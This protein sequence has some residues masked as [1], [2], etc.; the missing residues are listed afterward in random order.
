VQTFRFTIAS[1]SVAVAVVA[2]DAAWVKYVMTGRSVFGFAAAGA[3]CGL[4]LT[5][6]VLPFAL[7]AALTRRGEQRQYYAGFV[8]GGFAAALAFTC[9]TR[10]APE[11]VWGV[12][13]ATLGP[14]W[15]LL[16]EWVPNGTVF[17]VACM[18]LFLAAGLGAPQ[19][20]VALACG[21]RARRVFR[22]RHALR[23]KRVGGAPG[24]NA[25]GDGRSDCEHPVTPRE[26]LF[27]AI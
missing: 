5:A 3:D 1:L 6:N 14:V 10:L 15:D 24:G 12:A 7:R 25:P 22:R 11:V 19:L 23:C 16:F 20:V 2:L 9:C 18:M 27:D 4:F 13:V 21:S 17:R 26:W 8:A